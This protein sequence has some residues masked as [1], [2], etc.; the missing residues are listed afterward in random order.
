[1]GKNY[2]LEDYFDWLYE[3]VIPSRRNK[4]ASYRKLLNL[5]HDIEYRYY[6]EYDENRAADGEELRWRYVCDGGDRA[7]LKWNEPCT[8]LE[9]LIGLAYQMEG[10]MENPDVDYGVGYWFWMMIFNL[11]LDQMSDSRFNRCDVYEKVSIFMDREYA[12][13]GD[14]NIIYIQ[15]CREDLRNV[16]IWCQMCWYLDSIL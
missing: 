8:V 14:G 12:P 4:R 13:D 3:L 5:L 10:I 1:M 2:I 15:D 9:M 11:N 16:E 6:I 7:I